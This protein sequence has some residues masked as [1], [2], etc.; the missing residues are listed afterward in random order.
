MARFLGVSDP[1]YESYIKGHKSGKSIVR[2]RT[3]ITC[4]EPHYPQPNIMSL[5]MLLF[6]GAYILHHDAPSYD[7]WRQK[8]LLRYEGAAGLNS[9]KEISASRHR[10]YQN[11][12]EIYKR[13]DEKELKKFY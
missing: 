10:Q 1:F 11:I 3:D 12:V 4:L 7:I 9:E 8:W 6:S 13:G 5:N 2:L